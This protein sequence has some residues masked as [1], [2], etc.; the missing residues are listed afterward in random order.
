ME[1]CD[2]IYHSFIKQIII[3]S[4]TK[5]CGLTVTPAEVYVKYGDSA[6]INCS[7]TIKDAAIMSWEFAVGET[8]GASPP[9]VT[10]MI[11][12]LEDFTVEPFCF[13][14]L[15]TNEQCKMKPNITLYK[16]PDSV[17]V[18]AVGNRPMKEG[19][20]HQLQCHIY[21]VAPA[22]KLSVKWYKDDETVLTDDLQSSDVT[23][24]PKCLNDSTKSD[25]G[26][27][28]RCEAEFQFGPAGPLVP[29]SMASEPYTAVVHYKPTIKNCPSYYAGVENSFRLNDLPCETD[30]NPP[31]AIE[32]YYNGT[33]IDSFK[34]LT[35]AESGIY[36]ATAHNSM[37]QVNIDVHITVECGST[38]LNFYILLQQLLII[39][40]NI[41]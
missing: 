2:L 1:F 22:K 17:V 24:L 20:E 19:E 23:P 21:N 9:H 7:T 14:T 37:G 6:S 40:N 31:P 12:K 4:C 28:F 33:L 41:L 30:G 27:P 25:N 16:L 10:W 36:T 35:R 38:T 11:E 13:V 29:P 3:R 18:S 5:D 32:W 39:L 15:D 8:S 34:L 26:S